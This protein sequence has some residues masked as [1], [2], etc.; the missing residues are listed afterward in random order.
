MGGYAAPDRV[1]RVRRSL[2]R[3]IQQI[4][5]ARYCD[6]SIRSLKGGRGAP[7][8]LVL[9]GTYISFRQE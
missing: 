9:C 4:A 8:H 2:R 6:A 5:L 1:F 3:G 7:Q